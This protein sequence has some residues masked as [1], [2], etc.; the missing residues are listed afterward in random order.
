MNRFWKSAKEI[1]TELGDKRH[2]LTEYLSNVFGAISSLDINSTLAYINEYYRNVFR[3]CLNICE[4]KNE[5]NKSEF[6]EVVEKYK[7]KN[8]VSFKQ[9]HTKVEFY[10]ANILLENLDSFLDCFTENLRKKLSSIIDFSI[11][12]EKYNQIS[13]LVEK[14]KIEYLN[15][16]IY[17][18]FI[19][20]PVALV[21]VNEVVLRAVE[22]LTY[23]D[24]W[25][26]HNLFT[27][28]Q[29]AHLSKFNNRGEECFSNF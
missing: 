28:T 17:E 9:N 12:D 19:I 7:N 24:S 2:Y 18:S 26:L 25:V 15:D 11:I 22:M 8:N 5:K 29:G 13:K 23:R 21:A 10:A 14:E 27:I 6:Y 3:C 1:Q 4:C 20:S 16:L